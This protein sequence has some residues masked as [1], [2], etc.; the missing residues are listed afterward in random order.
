MR[1]A[2]V[3][4]GLLAVTAGAA[5][6][7][8]IVH[9]QISPGKLQL[10]LEVLGVQVAF[11]QNGGALATYK[12][13]ADLGIKIAEASKITFL[14]GPELQIGGRENLATIEFGAL[15]SMTFEKFLNIPLQPMARFGIGIPINV[16]YN[17]V[18]SVASGG[19]VIKFGGGVY[20][21]ILKMLAVGGE[22]NF[23]LGFQSQS[24]N[25]VTATGFFGYWDFLAG[26]R[27]AF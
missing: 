5:N 7:A 8:E 26:I 11:G 19:L 15:V 18:G 21:Y 16:F 4:L 1:S 14:I 27:L 13:N 12:L 23:A 10:N 6:G 9:G 2:L 24:N 20:Y 17:D 22:M 3:C 25:G